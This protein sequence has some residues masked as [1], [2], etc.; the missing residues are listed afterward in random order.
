MNRFFCVLAMLAASATPSIVH[1]ACSELSLPAT[2]SSPGNYCLAA[3]YT[4]SDPA[5]K[6]IT[7]AA[8]DVTVDC[9]GH[10]LSSNANSNNGT[11]V[12]IFA[13][14]RH[15]VTVRNCRIMGAYSIGI[16]ILQDNSGPNANYY[17]T[18]TDN[19]IGGP[20]LYGIRAYGSA[21]EILRNHIYDIGGQLN[22]HAAGIRIGSG[23]GFGF[24]LLKENLIA[25]TNSPYTNAFGIL[26]DKSVASI[27]IG[28]GTTGAYA[29]NT[30]YR[31]YGI[32]IL[33]GSGNRIT[34]NHVNG[35][36]HSNDVG[37]TTNDT[38]SSCFDNYIR[39][40][41]KTTTCNASL[42]NY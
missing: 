4:T 39:A 2:I 20:Y 19:Y 16:D 36:G 9:Q 8:H 29:S 35:S 25:G 32:R 41:T 21:L 34:D 3:D 11:S 24:H 28:N 13:N 6:S 26:S 27:F 42:G 33:G 30:A 12:A 17:V 7:I 14:N 31:G 37:I 18:I 22:S 5:E 10:T 38:A 23:T 1:A 15:D 40:A